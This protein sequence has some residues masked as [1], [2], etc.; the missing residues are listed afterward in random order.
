[1]EGASTQKLMI[2]LCFLFEDF[3]G[4]VE[5]AG[6]PTHLLSLRRPLLVEAKY[7]LD[8]WIRVKIVQF[9]IRPKKNRITVRS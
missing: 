7:K 2:L 1:M 8:F 4:E 9:W 5:E 6:V 3:Q